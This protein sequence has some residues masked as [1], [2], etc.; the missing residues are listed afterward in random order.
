VVVRVDEPRQHHLAARVDA[1]LGREPG[2]RRRRTDRDDAVVLDQHVA[3][4]V[5]AAGVVHRRDESRVVDERPHLK[6]S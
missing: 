5:A 4:R 6:N 2:R 1:A 3:A